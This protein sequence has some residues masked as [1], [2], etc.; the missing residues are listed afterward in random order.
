MEQEGEEYM[1]PLAVTV[2]ELLNTLDEDDYKA[3]I[4]FIEY[5]S[6]SKKK[7][8]AEKSR[9]MLSEIQNIFEDDKGWDSEQDMLDEMAAFRKERM[10]I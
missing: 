9:D 2:N 10:G 1:A 4:S 7:K 8:R 6:I 5:L 3:A